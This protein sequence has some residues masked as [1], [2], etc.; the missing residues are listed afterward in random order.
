[1]SSNRILKLH[2]NGTVE[3]NLIES[4]LLADPYAIAVDRSENVYVSDGDSQRL[5]PDAVTG[6][7]QIFVF[8]K[9]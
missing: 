1:M 4:P 9:N 7:H 5:D 8:D 3:S 6:A 2:F